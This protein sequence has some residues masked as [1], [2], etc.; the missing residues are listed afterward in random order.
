[1]RSHYKVVVVIFFW[2]FFSDHY[3]KYKLYY[4]YYWFSYSRLDNKHECWLLRMSSTSIVY[5]IGIHLQVASVPSPWQIRVLPFI[6]RILTLYIYTI[7]FTPTLTYSL[8]GYS[9][10]CVANCYYRLWSIIGLTLFVTIHGSFLFIIT[11]KVSDSLR[12]FNQKCQKRQKNIFS[13]SN[14]TKFWLW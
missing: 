9:P 1:M 7:H 2:A 11:E 12:C 5:Q 3:L 8:K 13:P 14:H 10:H 4:L 6:S